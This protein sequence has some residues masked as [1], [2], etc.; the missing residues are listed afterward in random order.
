[1]P[2]EHVARAGEEVPIVDD[3]GGRVVPTHAHDCRNLPAR[4]LKKILAKIIPVTRHLCCVGPAQKLQGF[5]SNTLLR[6]LGGRHFLPSSH[7]S[8]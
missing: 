7:V 2:H 6:L 3:G 1:M 8:W 5:S 4:Q